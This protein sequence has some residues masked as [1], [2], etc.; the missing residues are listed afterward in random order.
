MFVHGEEILELTNSYRLTDL[1]NAHLQ[2]VIDCLSCIE[3]ISHWVE[4]DVAGIPVSCN[5]SRGIVDSDRL[6]IVKEASLKH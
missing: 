4:G 6:R 3:T 1:A 2:G 5:N